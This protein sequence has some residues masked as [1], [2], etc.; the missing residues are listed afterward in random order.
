MIKR[1]LCPGNRNRYTAK[2][3]D[4]DLY[5]MIYLLVMTGLRR[6][7]LMALDWQSVNFADKALVVR[8]AFTRGRFH[9]PKTKSSRRSVNLTPSAL[10]ILKE[11]RLKMGN[12]DGIDLLFDQGDGTPLSPPRLS[13]VLWPRLLKRAG[14]RESVRLHDLRH[15]F[16]S[17][18]LAQGASPKYIQS[19]LGHSSIMITM[20]LYGH[21]MP[22]VN[23]RES[24]RLD[25]TVFGTEE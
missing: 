22:E 3:T 5:V 7:E 18:L 24:E 21:L 4:W 13:K 2:Q 10:K 20:D 16:C 12:P 19:Q 6:G 17:L 8:R 15:T 9:E 11:H 1:P 23:Q 25:E 14:I